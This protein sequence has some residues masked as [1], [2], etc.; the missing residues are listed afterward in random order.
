MVCVNKCEEN[1]VEGDQMTQCLCNKSI[2]EGTDEK[3]VAERFI[4]AYNDL[5]NSLNI[6]PIDVTPRVTE[7]MEDIIEFIDKMVK[8]GSAYEVNGDV[9]FSVDSDSKYINGWS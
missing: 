9:Y 7:T 3:E 6:I 5:R 8:N 1:K 2:E 4:K